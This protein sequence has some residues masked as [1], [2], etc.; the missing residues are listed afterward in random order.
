VAF[1]QSCDRSRDTLY[2]V[3][4]SCE[5]K[6][7]VAVKA[8]AFS[9]L[10]ARS[11]VGQE[12]LVY[13]G[14]TSVV[15]LELTSTSSEIFASRSVFESSQRRY[16]RRQEPQSNDTGEVR[17][18]TSWIRLSPYIHYIRAYLKKHRWR[19]L[20][21]DGDESVK[22][23]RLQHQCPLLFQLAYVDEF[24]YIQ[25]PFRDELPRIIL[26]PPPTSSIWPPRILTPRILVRMT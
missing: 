1:H 7:D 16:S 12:D 23:H 20:V 17:S 8:A 15:F 4:S 24:W 9:E 22:S 19:V 6:F 21:V 5:A 11:A 26:F 2:I 13:P 10:Y 14:D 25:A 3:S 18:Y